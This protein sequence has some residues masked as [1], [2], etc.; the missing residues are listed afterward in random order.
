[1]NNQGS[2]NG[3]IFRLAILAFLAMY[4]WQ[5][6]NAQKNQPPP[7][8]PR[9]VPSLAQAFA[10]ISRT[11]L[12]EEAKPAEAGTDAAKTEASKADADKAAAAEKPAATA[13]PAGSATPTPTTEPAVK[14]AGA[15]KVV[16]LLTAA[17]GDAE[18]TKL[19]KEITAVPHDEY[20]YWARLRI[21]LIEQYVLKKVTLKE[22]P[23]SVWRNMFGA[24]YYTPPE[25]TVFDEITDHGAINAVDAQALYQK[26]N[27]LWDANV[28]KGGKEPSQSAAHALEQLIH[29]GRGSSQFLD[30]KI[31]TPIKVAGAAA[32]DAPEFRLEAV[33]DLRETKPNADTPDGIL[34]RVN[35][36]HKT[37]IF[38]KLFDA[39][40]KLFGSNPTYSYGLAVIF[41]AIVTRLL[42][43]PLTKKQYESMKGM[44]VIA[45]EMK[46]IQDKYKGKSDQQA[47]V[48][49]MKEIRE[50]QHRHGVNPMMGCALALV[51]MPI[52]FF[53]VY[54]LIQH[55]EPQMELAGASFLWIYSLA[56]PD[57][58]LLVLYGISMFLSFRLSSTPPTDEQQKMMQ[59]MMAFIFPI[60]FPFV[61]KS[62]PSAFT[63]YWMM[64]N[65][66][67]TTF[68]WRM[69]KAAD[70][71]KS[72][73]KALMGTG[74]PLPV[75]AVPERPAKKDS[76][77]TKDSK[78]SKKTASKASD[79]VPARTSQREAR[80]ESEKSSTYNVELNGHKAESSLNGADGDTDDDAL[81]TTK[82]GQS[83]TKSSS[84]QRARRRRRY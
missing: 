62:Y 34:N 57:I 65:V 8:K 81:S 11:P 49:M 52:F 67:S 60:F 43:Q 77:E 74:E 78:E 3:Q 44:Q 56:Q 66:V 9:E 24:F 1:M 61:L 32:T 13:A 80:G 42:I 51:Q 37:T 58:L 54:P 50:L 41:F 36:Y 27:W 30:L 55:Y 47:Q 40:V 69:M 26:G 72:I 79:A 23:P 46:K 82:K 20:A 39:V 29:K 12:V 31:Y 35:E 6:W 38:Y 75:A 84:S 2:S 70:P 28:E 14:P 64:F 68:Q 5:S 21:G 25:Y 59:T 18:I 48:Q 53:F 45:P 7:V 19:Q 76:K 63:M 73:I 4:F 10:G 83:E 71:D 16:P 15:D 17:T 22:R 33:K